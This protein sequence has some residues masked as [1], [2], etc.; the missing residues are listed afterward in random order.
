MSNSTITGLFQL[1]LDQLRSVQS[2]AYGR[3]LIPPPGQQQLGGLPPHHLRR[4]QDDLDR[5]TDALRRHGIECTSTLRHA[6]TSYASKQHDASAGSGI[7][8]RIGSGKKMIIRYCVE[9]IDWQIFCGF[10][11]RKQP[12]RRSRSRRGFQVRQLHSQVSPCSTRLHRS[13]MQ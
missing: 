9:R 1:F 13:P 11:R 12:R 4:S 6:Y 7:L 3:H 8:K 5:L 10:G 2:S